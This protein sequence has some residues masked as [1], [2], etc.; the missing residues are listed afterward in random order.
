MAADVG[1]ALG[2]GTDVTRDSAAVCLLGDDLT[3]IAW[4]LELAQETVRTIRGNLAWAFGYNFVGVAIAAAG[5]LHPAVAAVLMAVSS[6]VVI[7]RS[8]RLGCADEGRPGSTAAAREH[9]P[10]A[11][12]STVPA[13][14][15]AG[16]AASEAAP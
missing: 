16:L 12:V 4:A 9:L 10:R 2:C 11:V 1:I 3:R 5:W 15:A 14:A 6:G 7:A 13:A 8:R